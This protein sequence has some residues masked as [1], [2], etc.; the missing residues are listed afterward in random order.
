MNTDI[1]S[2]DPNRDSH[3]EIDA[4]GDM[5][6]RTEFPAHVFLSDDNAE[7]ERLVTEY[8]AVTRA[9][10]FHKHGVLLSEQP[11]G[12]RAIAAARITHNGQVTGYRQPV[13]SDDVET[14]FITL[15]W[16]GAIIELPEKTGIQTWINL[17][18]IEGLNYLGALRSLDTYRGPRISPL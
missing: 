15:I 1:R 5:V 14:A 17:R 4:D 3:A 18:H 9:H 16:T 7:M 11:S 6:A 2:W 12:A 8:A 13:T 10:M